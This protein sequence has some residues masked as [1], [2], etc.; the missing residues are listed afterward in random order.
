MVKKIGIATI[1]VAASLS[2]S[3]TRA[4]EITGDIL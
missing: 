2:L 4:G 3:H 1:M